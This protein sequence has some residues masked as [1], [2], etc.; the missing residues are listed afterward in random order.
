MSTDPDRCD[1]YD[2]A[3]LVAR[4]EISSAELVE[5]A[6]ERIESVNDRVNAVVTKIYDRARERALT[7]LTGPFAGVPILLKELAA[8][9]GLPSTLASV[10]CADSPTGP[11]P[12]FVRRIEAAGFVVLGRTNS[13]EFG[14]LPI[15][16]PELFGATANPWALSHDCGGSSGG[17]AAAVA[18][19][20]LPLAQGGDAGGSLR[21]PASA[22]GVFALKPSRG[23][24]SPAPAANAD[25]F[26]THHV[27]TRTV[28]DSAAFLDAVMGSFRGDR[29]ICPG[30]PESFASAMALPPGRLRI[31]VAP[32]GFMAGRRAHAECARAV[33]IAAEL[34][35]SLGHRV[36]HAAPSVDHVSANEAFLTLV[37][38]D[39]ARAVARL[40]AQRGDLPRH[41]LGK[42]TW[43]MADLG[44]HYPPWA[45]TAANEVLQQAAYQVADFQLRYDVIVTPVMHRPPVRLGEIID[46]CEFPELR[47]RM[48]EY[49]PHTALMNA[50]GQP[51]MSIP[52]HW[53]AEGLPVGVQFIGRY[54]EDA[55]L[56]KLARQIESARPWADRR[57]PVHAR[58]MDRRSK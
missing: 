36:E 18:A 49:C 29:W 53:T 24:I 31:A 42:W 13:S 35:A 58:R 2:M 8:Y 38:I 46:E 3:A 33:E 12:E 54:G 44:A 21:I 10:A 5:A 23:R 20:M 26:G 48:L 11:I 16:Q 15:T 52:L 41:L 45:A 32:D 4:G 28:R 25:G 9:P 40:R 56:Y 1:A 50:S 47:A 34:C 6:I 22:C 55:G 14:S 57:P 30:E 19:G 43:G 39:A 37:A 27:V 7:P 17:A 51:A